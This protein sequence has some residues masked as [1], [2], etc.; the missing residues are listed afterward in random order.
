LSLLCMILV[1]FTL[2]SGSRLVWVAS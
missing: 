2:R 1:P